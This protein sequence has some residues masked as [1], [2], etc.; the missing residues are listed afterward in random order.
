MDLEPLT[1]DF[2]FFAA[3]VPWVVPIFGSDAAAA[4]AAVG[5]DDDAVADEDAD[6]EKDGD[7]LAAEEKRLFGVGGNSVDATDVSLRRL[8]LLCLVLEFL[9]TFSSSSDVSDRFKLS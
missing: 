8:D 5:D 4:A 3:G 1:S 2:I 7:R 9:V 6:D